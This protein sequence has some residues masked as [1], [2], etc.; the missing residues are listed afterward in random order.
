MD[1]S[2]L[3]K[4]QVDGI[5]RVRYLVQPLDQSVYWAGVECD[6]DDSGEGHGRVR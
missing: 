6:K 4:S 1:Y 5:L 3:G 2:I